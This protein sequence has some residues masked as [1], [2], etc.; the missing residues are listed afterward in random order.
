MKSLSAQVREQRRLAKAAETLRNSG[1]KRDYVDPDNKQQAAQ[2]VC[3][4]LLELRNIAHSAHLPQLTY[5]LEMAFY[6]AF[7]QASKPHSNK[8]KQEPSAKQMRAPG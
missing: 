6:E 8:G 7:E 2:F 4:M 5:F 1:H 3:D